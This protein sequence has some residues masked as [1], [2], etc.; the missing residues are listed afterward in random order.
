MKIY[1]STQLMLTETHVIKD[2][3]EFWSIWDIL[4]MTNGTVAN[5]K[6]SRLL[7]PYTSACKCC[8]KMVL[9]HSEIILG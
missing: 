7:Q 9:N 5:E 2:D 6:L 1:T 8:H 3:D 4:D